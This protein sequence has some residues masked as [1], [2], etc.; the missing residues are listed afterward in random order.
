[1][2]KYR[3]TISKASYRI[4]RHCFATLQRETKFA[5]CIPFGYLDRKIFI[6]GGND[7]KKKMKTEKERGKGKKERRRKNM[8][9]K[10]HIVV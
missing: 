2:K 9:G 4:P 8:D 5:T 7:N 10:T 3:V 1:M 6:D